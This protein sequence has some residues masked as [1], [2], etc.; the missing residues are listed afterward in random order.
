MLSQQIRTC[1]QGW[2]NNGN[3]GSNGNSSDNNYI[4]GNCGFNDCN[5]GEFRD[6]FQFSIPSFSGP[7]LTADL[8]LQT[9]ST[10][11][12]QS[13]SL[14]YQVTSLPATFGFGDLG[15]GTVD[16]TRIYT[17]TDANMTE[18]IPL[19]AAAFTD[20][21]AA[22]GDTFGVGGRA[23]SAITFGPTAQD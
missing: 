20:I 1:G 14:T 10:V 11:L 4:V 3:H 8:V 16:G 15:T 12:D 22:G 5:A 13:P 9:W 17:S 6:F 23:I 19:D 21:K 2:I 7:I 18:L